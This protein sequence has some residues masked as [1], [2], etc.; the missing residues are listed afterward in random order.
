[1][2]RENP[3][4]VTGCP[5]NFSRSEPAPLGLVSSKDML[6]GIQH[7]QGKLM[8][9]ACNHTERKCVCMHMYMFVC[10]CV[11]MYMHVCTCVR[12]YACIC[13]YMCMHVL[14]ICVCLCMCVC[15]N[16]PNCQ[17][18][19]WLHQWLFSPMWRNIWPE[20]PERRRLYLG[21]SFRDL[22]TQGRTADAFRR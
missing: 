14:Y 13:V 18:L 17:A 21:S 4:R 7:Q 8:G 12:T 20:Q 6:S 9:E 11:Y 3:S 16:L 15:P 19:P 5:L 2:L 22:S 1:M 10:V